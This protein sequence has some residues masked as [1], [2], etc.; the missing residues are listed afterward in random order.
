[1]KIQRLTI[2]A[3]LEKVHHRRET[4]RPEVDGYII[5]GMEPSQQS[6]TGEEDIVK[7]VPILSSSNER[8]VL[9]YKVIDDINGKR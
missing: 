1:M 5:E 9:Q 2:S 6:S 7:H 3:I 4:R 8:S